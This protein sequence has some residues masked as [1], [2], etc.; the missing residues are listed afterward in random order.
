M[1][2]KEFLIGKKSFKEL[3]YNILE[4]CFASPAM[5]VLFLILFKLFDEKA[6]F[7]PYFVGAAIIGILLLI[8]RHRRLNRKHPSDTD[9][10]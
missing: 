5:Y 6:I 4:I 10:V 7:I 2:L 1:T 3:F 9:G 8:R